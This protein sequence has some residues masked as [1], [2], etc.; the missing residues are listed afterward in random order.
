MR[1]PHYTFVILMLLRLPLIAQGD[2]LRFFATK[3]AQL[4]HIYPADSAEFSRSLL[5]WARSAPDT[6]IDQMSARLDTLT[7]NRTQARYRA[8][9]SGFKPLLRRISSA[10]R[11]GAIDALNFVRLYSEYDDFLGYNLFN[12]FLS[13]STRNAA[14]ICFERFAASARIDTS[15]IRAL[16]VLDQHIC[17]EADLSE[18]TGDFVREAL[19]NNPAGF[20]RMYLRSDEATRREMREYV[21]PDGYPDG[22]IIRK[23]SAISRAPNNASLIKVAREILDSIPYGPPAPPSDDFA[24]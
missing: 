3:V 10:R 18:A 21:A 6:M 2:R 11:P 1:L 15:F 23:L 24:P 22:G 5:N 4:G 12:H 14:W 19:L 20:L 13:D 9:E 7:L 17:I 8:V 16:I